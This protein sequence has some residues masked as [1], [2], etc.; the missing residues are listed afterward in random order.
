MSDEKGLKTDYLSCH[1]LQVS[2]LDI[3]RLCFQ[4]IAGEITLDS[5]HTH[6]TV[7]HDIYIYISCITVYI[8]I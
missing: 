8:Y 7:I 1:H 2:E 6:F 5:D 3:G 4:A